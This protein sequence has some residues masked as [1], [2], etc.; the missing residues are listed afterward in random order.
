MPRKE[1]WLTGYVCMLTACV[2]MSLHASLLTPSLLLPCLLYSLI[3]NYRKAS[4]SL[5]I[6]HELYA[7]N[8][9]LADRLK[10]E[11]AVAMA[12]NEQLAQ[13]MGEWARTQSAFIVAK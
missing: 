9:A 13:C 10:E 2:S 12:H 11:M 6:I 1:P 7:K 3:A 5:K 4:G 8:G